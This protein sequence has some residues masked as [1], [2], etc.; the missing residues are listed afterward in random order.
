[1]VFKQTFSLVLYEA[2]QAGL[3]GYFRVFSYSSQLDSL[4]QIKTADQ[5]SLIWI[6][7]QIFAKSSWKNEIFGTFYT[8]GLNL[9]LSW[10]TRML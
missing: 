4:I 3:A 10:S 7:D 8:F 2:S 1:M 5:A 9:Y 6:I